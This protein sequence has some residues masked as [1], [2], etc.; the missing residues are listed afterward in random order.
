MT[1]EGRVKKECRDWLDSHPHYYR[2]APVPM[3]YGKRTLDELVCIAGKFVAL[4]YKRKSG[5]GRRDQFQEAVCQ[6]VR[7]AGGVAIRGIKS[8]E[9]LVSGLK[10]AGF[11]IP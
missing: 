7:K 3:G 1:P 8:L 9:D 2:Y 11:Y 10:M 6:D 4:E 5:D